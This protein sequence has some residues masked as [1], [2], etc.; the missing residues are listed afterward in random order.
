MF[1][2]VPSEHVDCW[3]D[4]L[5]GTNAQNEARKGIGVHWCVYTIEHRCLCGIALPER[6]SEFISLYI[7]FNTNTSRE[8]RRGF[9]V[10]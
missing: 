2:G 7:I 10:H 1:A 4:K 3:R 5:I 9:D 6:A 8:A